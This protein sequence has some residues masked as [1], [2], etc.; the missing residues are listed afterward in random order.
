TFLAQL[1]QVVDLENAR[2]YPE[3]PSDEHFLARLAAVRAT[4]TDPFQPMF[5]NLQVLI[6]LA[7]SPGDLE[8][9][10]I[11]GHPAL[12]VFSLNFALPSFSRS[13]EADKESGALLRVTDALLQ[14]LYRWI[15]SLVELVLL[16]LPWAELAREHY[17]A[18]LSL[19][20]QLQDFTGTGEMAEHTY[21]TT[22]LSHG[23]LRKL[24]LGAPPPAATAWGSGRPDAGV[25]AGGVPGVYRLD[26]LELH[27]TLDVTVSVLEIIAPRAN[28]K[29]LRLRLKAGAG[30]VASLADALSSVGSSLERLQVD[31]VTDTPQSTP[32]QPATWA[33][34]SGLYTACPSLVALSLWSAVPQDLFGLTDRDLIAIGLH[35]K[36]L[37]LL[38]LHWQDNSQTVAP[39]NAPGVTLLGLLD[40]LQSCNS[41][42][43]ILMTSVR[44]PSPDRETDSHFPRSPIIPVHRRAEVFVQSLQ[45]PSDG[46]RGTTEL[47]QGA[48]VFLGLNAPFLLF[49][50]YGKHPSE[51]HET[52]TT[53]Q[54]NVRDLNDLLSALR[55]YRESET[56]SQPPS[57]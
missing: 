14:R 6:C 30:D 33:T 24:C 51:A 43:H 56:D 19:A 39:S 37:R 35:W 4:R 5:P 34:F 52:N 15:P 12:K 8:V 50:S 9:L 47:L 40:L 26:D 31:F 13:K 41:L 29:V 53:V 16:G 21:L 49:R 54:P 2:L 38:S 18:L 32:S 22:L 46:S 10:H 25:H 42:S 3:Y 17:G 36:H 44:L 7:G 20:V 27:H 23:A 45:G 1:V 55:I 57:F 11:L 48:A 28:L